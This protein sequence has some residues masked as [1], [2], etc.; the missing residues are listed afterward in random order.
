MYVRTIPCQLTAYLN[1]SPPINLLQK[2]LYTK[3]NIVTHLQG[4]KKNDALAARIT[5]IHQSAFG[6]PSLFLG[7]SFK[8]I[9]NWNFY[10]GANQV[11]LC[12][13]TGSLDCCS[14]VLCCLYQVY[15]HDI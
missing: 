1:K 10:A 11:T 12:I 2:C 8:D 7:I 15:F 13:F 9:S 6:A 3:C 14:A 5:K 4:Q